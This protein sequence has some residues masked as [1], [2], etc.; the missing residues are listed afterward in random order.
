MSRKIAPPYPLKI[1]FFVPHLMSGGAEK[2]FVN[3]ANY[4]SEASDSDVYLMSSF[5]G[6]FDSQVHSTVTT[7]DLRGKTIFQTINI[8]KDLQADIIISTLDAANIRN[9]LFKL[10]IRSR[11]LYITRVPSICT[12]WYK[13]SGLKNKIHCLLGAMAYRYSDYVIANS[14]DSKESCIRHCWVNEN[15]IYVIGNPVL[16]QAEISS[17]RQERLHHNKYVLAVGSFK[18]QKR[19]DLLIDVFEKVL[20]INDGLELWIAGDGGELKNE[21]IKLIEKKGISDKVKLLGRSSELKDLYT[22][23]E[24]LILTS[25]I[26][27]FGNVIVE[28]MACGTVPVCFNCPG[29]P[30]YI[31]DEGQ[32]GI[33]VPFGDTDKMAE[34][35][36]GLIDGRI[37]YNKQLL[38]ERSRYFTTENMGNIYFNTMKELY[39]SKFGKL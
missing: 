27:G 12:S 18:I 37:V 21:I 8:V 30:H 26:E 31:L 7:I 19:F 24:C 36:T 9:A 32:Y 13:Q 39:I 20:R 15:K 34:S 16:S 4:I 5:G 23:S 2:V 33:L 3:L 17:I 22:N 10:C 11:T 25:E 1:I 14:P 35:I 28:S 29:G 6:F 38:R